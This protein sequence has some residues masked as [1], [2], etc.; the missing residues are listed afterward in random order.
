MEDQVAAS[1]SE[2]WQRQRAQLQEGLANV[3]A[4]T[5]SGIVRQGREDLCSRRQVWRRQYRTINSFNAV[6]PILDDDDDEDGGDDYRVPLREYRSAEEGKKS[7]SRANSKKNNMRS[8]EEESKKVIGK[9]DRL[10]VKALW[11]YLRHRSSS[12]PQ[13]RA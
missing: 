12:R 11:N 3:K 2:L 9:R 6:A 7:S 10:Q 5:S 4:E 1:R 13:R 8:V